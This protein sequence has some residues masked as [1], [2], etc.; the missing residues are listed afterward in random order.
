MPNLTA[1][2]HAA[3]HAEITT[4]PARLGYAGQSATA[5][6]ALLNTTNQSLP[7]G[8][9]TGLGLLAVLAHNLP[10]L[11]AAPPSPLAQWL[12]SMVSSVVAQEPI[13]PADPAFAALRDGLFPAATYPRTNATLASLGHRPASRAEVVLGGGAIIDVGDVTTALSLAPAHEQA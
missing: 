5:I 9:A 12:L 8:L 3:L 6:S 2:Q 7:S 11:A 4:D 13:S 10:E 1:A